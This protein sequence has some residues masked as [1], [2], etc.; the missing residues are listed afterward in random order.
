MTMTATA[1]SEGRSE[2]ATE[3]LVVT[4]SVFVHDSVYVREAGDTVFLSRWRTCWRERTVHDTVVERLTDTI[5]MTETLEVE[6][7]V[8]VPKKGGNVGWIVA[9]V[10]A[11]LM[12]VQ[13][14]IK[15]TLKR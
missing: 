5:R 3:T 15:T 4:D 6:K 9:A 11:F 12:T 8:E 14:V 10:L 1:R 13:T 7:T 2:T